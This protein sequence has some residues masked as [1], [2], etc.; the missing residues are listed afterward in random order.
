MCVVDDADTSGYKLG[1]SGAINRGDG[2]GGGGG[3]G[4][5][6]CVQASQMDGAARGIERTK[7]LHA[8]TRQ[9]R[10]GE[11]GERE[12][13]KGGDIEREG[14]GERDIEVIGCIVAL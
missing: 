5:S 2:G 1:Q 8:P 10:G 13:E 4:S 12:R 3:G 6:S 11:R 7:S 14:E 9:G